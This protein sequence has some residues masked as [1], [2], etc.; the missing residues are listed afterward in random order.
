MHID[1]QQAPN[2]KQAQLHYKG[3]E[4]WLKFLKVHSNGNFEFQ[5]ET[6]CSLMLHQSFY[7]CAKNVEVNWAADR[8]KMAEPK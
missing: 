1:V 5:I 3:R 4:R 2:P 7:I 8:T 6:F